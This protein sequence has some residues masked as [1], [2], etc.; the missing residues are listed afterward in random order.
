MHALEYTNRFFIFVFAKGVLCKPQ[1]LDFLTPI[2][3]LMSGLFR[4]S[5]L[6]LVLACTGL[7]VSAQESVNAAGG[8]ATGSGGSVAY[9]IGQVFFTS[10]S[11][12][13]GS[14]S[15]GVQQAHEILIVGAQE[16]APGFS[17]EAFPNPSHDVLNLH[18]SELPPENQHY[19][20]FDT[21]GKEIKEGLIVQKDTRIELGH[22]ATGTYFLKIFS[23]ASPSATEPKTIQVIVR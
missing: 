10:Q 9:S 4:I 12:S 11:N 23:P 3:V 20:M 8:D 14:L 22:L 17:V 13:S 2:N 19:V 1:R 16:T 7:N 15:E 6:V 5:T 18:F 21:Q